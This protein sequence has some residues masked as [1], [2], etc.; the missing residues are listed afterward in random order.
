MIG[1]SSAYYLRYFATGMTSYAGTK[2]L[3]TYISK[4]HRDE[5]KELG[6]R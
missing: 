3:A 2:A 5:M 6:D 1:V 4:G